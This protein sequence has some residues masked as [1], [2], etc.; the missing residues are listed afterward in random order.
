M[1]AKTALYQEHLNLG[2]KVVD[3]AGWDMPL[4]YGSQVEEHY[5]VRGDAGMFDV[6][7]MTFVDLK[8][9]RVREF[10]CYLL[11]NNVDRLKSPGRA[12]YT[13]ML[14]EQGG[15]VDDLIVNSSTDTSND[16]A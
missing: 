1:G 4:H 7:H 5:K 10:L 11:A 3:F 16:A 12:L 6:S 2:A 13:C 9:A 8:G 15:V 14:N